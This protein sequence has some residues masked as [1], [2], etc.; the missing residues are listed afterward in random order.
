MPSAVDAGAFLSGFVPGVR[1]GQIAGPERPGSALAWPNGV[2]HALSLAGA[3]LQEYAISGD[4]VFD[5]C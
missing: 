5:D 3:V 4:V 1:A 2:D